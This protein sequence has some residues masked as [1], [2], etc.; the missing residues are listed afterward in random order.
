MH[1]GTL[2]FVVVGVYFTGLLLLGRLFQDQDSSTDYFLA[3]RQNSS[4]LAGISV[5]ATLLSTVTYLALPGEMIRNGAGYFTSLLAFVLVIPTV[6]RLII[7]ML[8]RLQAAS[9]YDY[10]ERRYNRSVRL[11]GAGLFVG[12]RLTW[13]SLILYIAARSL[14]PMTNWN[15]PLLI[16]LTGCV[17]L[18][19]TTLGGM[20][21]VVWSDFAQFVILFGG[22]LFV[23]LYIGVQTS[24]T[25]VDWLR[26]F[27][28]A[29]RSSVP[30]FSIDPT[31]RTSVVGMILMLY[32]WNICTHGA[33]QVAA[34]RYLSTPSAAAAKRSFW[35]FS[36]GN[37]CLLLLIMVVG[38][39]LFYFRYDA[40]GL[41]IGEF[42][43]AIRPT[44]DDV[45]PQ[46]L[47]KQLPQGA[48]GLMLAALLAAA[49]SSVSSGINSIAAVVSSDFLAAC[50]EQPG[51]ESVKRLR[52]VSMATGVGA[53]LGA[54]ATNE[55]MLRADW[56]FVE[57]ME[58]INH[59]FVAPLG[60][61]FFAGICFRR[62]GSTAV[63]IGFAAGL[64]AS[65]GV[66][67]SAALFDYNVSFM[68]IMPV[69]FLVTLLVSLASAV[70][71]P[72][73]R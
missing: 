5:V 7:P 64:L 63:L 25:P 6:N 52:T 42:Q 8:M 57:L 1:L 36:I 69:S 59:L 13:M 12:M 73:D 53:V 61:L 71:W 10:L 26:V 24:S 14:H 39:A 15:V 19:Y 44:A 47:A 60:G 38:L 32:V 70:A 27:N 37:V 46:F 54:L 9:I 43:E 16:V 40:A 30:L 28:E 35:V 68:W 20:R 56:N 50:S 4:W 45:F 23:P 34:Q 51:N 49:M 48:S 17:T 41:S 22:V 21:A 62:V 3:G 29:E 11:L 2:D 18:I 33:D 31:E 67:F 65:V 72:G 58:R 55:M 66:S